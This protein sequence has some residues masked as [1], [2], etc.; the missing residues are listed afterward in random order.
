MPAPSPAIVLAPHAYTTADA[1]TA[2]GL[3]RGTER[4][5]IVA[6]VDPDCAGR[7]AGELLDGRHRAIP[8]VGDLEQ[9]VAI[10][11]GRVRHCIVGVATHGGR[12]TPL[13][14]RAL[15]DAAR[16]GLAIVNGLHDPA[17]EDPDIAA[18]AAA[19]GVEIIDLRRVR[20]TRELHHWEGHVREVRAARVAVL[21]TDC[22]LGKRTTARMLV[23]ALRGAGISAEMIYTGQTGWMQG[24]RYGFVLD[25]TPNDYV[26]GELEHALVAC[27]REVAPDVMVIEGQSSLRNPSGPCGSE[28]ILAGGARAVVLQHAPGRRFLDGFE[29]LGLP[30]PDVADE[31]ALVRHLGAE[32][33]AVT[34]NGEGLTPEALERH[35]A[36][37]EARIGIPVVSVLEQG[38]DRVVGPIRAHLG[39]TRGQSPAP[40]PRASDED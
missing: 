14:R 17:A 34:L 16:R 24:A 15:A 1:K 6:V 5:E 37:L 31:I 19:S 21:G 38:L 40:G 22:A 28:L 36:A 12:L 8:V 3:V 2:H 13:L 18:A 7:D 9:G 25:A 11:A 27:D 26:C 4:F 10:A 29:A 39:R 30:L 35:R 20:P 23:Q 32:T 33:L